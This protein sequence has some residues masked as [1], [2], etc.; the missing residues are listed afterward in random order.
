MTER[1]RVGCRDVNGRAVACPDDQIAIA[2]GA[3]RNAAHHARIAERYHHIAPD[4]RQRAPPYIGDCVGLAAFQSL[5]PGGEVIEQCHQH[6]LTIY[7][8]ADFGGNTGCIGKRPADKDCA[9]TTDVHANAK[10]DCLQM[11][12]A[13]RRVTENARKFP[14]IEQEII[15]PLDDGPRTGD[16]RNGVNTGQRGDHCQF[17][18][19]MYILWPEN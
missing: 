5:L 2:R 19:M 6:R 14:V 11:R 1:A 16:R 10:P 9:L 4:C 8:M 15:R 13:P 18:H 17:G 3:H 7:I 12:P